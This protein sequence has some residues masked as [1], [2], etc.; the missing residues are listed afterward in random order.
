MVTEC[1]VN[2]ACDV[3]TVFFDCMYKMKYSCYQGS[4]VI[5]GWFNL[6]IGF[7]VEICAACQS[8]KSDFGVALFLF[9]TLLDA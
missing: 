5:H 9:F 6:F 2:S 7:L 4:S 1:C 3:L 8:W